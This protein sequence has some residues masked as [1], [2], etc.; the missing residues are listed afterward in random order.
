MSKEIPIQFSVI[1]DGVSKKKDSTLS[2]KLGTQE[3]PPE[4]TAKIFELGGKQIWCG[5]AETPITRLDV[6]DEV[7]EFDNDKS[8]SERLR[9]TLWVYWDTKT[10][11][12]QTFEE[13]RK[14]QM[15]KFINLI[16]DKL[17]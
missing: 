2:I 8:L 10:K 17:D 13:F 12:T 6:P 15:E 9:N 11:H 1:I 14:I 3:L 4:D 16:K 5:L 7:M